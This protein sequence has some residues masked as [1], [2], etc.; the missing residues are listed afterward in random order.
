MSKAS[1][2]RAKASAKT[3]GRLVR[4]TVAVPAAVQSSVCGMFFVSG[5]ASLV[6]QVLWFKL[7]Q[8][9][10]GSSTYSVSVT[11]ASFFLGLALGSWLGGR[12]ADRW[13]HPLRNYG[14]LEI[15]LAGVSLLITVLLCRWQSWA[16]WLGPYLEIDSPLARPVTIGISFLLLL[17]PTMLMGATLPILVKYL[18]REQRALADQ[19]GLLYG[20]NTFGA[21]VG[22]AIAGFCLIA[23]FGIFQSA[24]VA[25][26]LYLVIG[27]AAL[28]LSGTF[29]KGDALFG[30]LTNADETD[31]A[32]VEAISRDAPAKGW[33]SVGT[34]VLVFAVS[35]F[36]SIAYEIIWFRLIANLGVHSVYAFSGMLTVYLL[37]LVL[38]SLVCAR[39]LARH[40]ER[41]LLY[42][43]RLQ[44]GIAV[45]AMLS[46]AIMGR[47]RMIV[48]I[49]T[50]MLAD[51]GIPQT[52]FDGLDNIQG[53]LL[54][55]LLVLLIPTVLI[56][57]GFPLASELTIRRLSVLGRRLG[58]LYALNTVGGV[59]GS[60]GAGFVLLPLLGS[61]WSLLLLCGMNLALFAAV[62]LSQPSLRRDR[63]LWREAAGAAVMIIV[64]LFLLGPDY[65]KN[66]LT[67]SIRGEVVAFEE[68]AE[69]TFVVIQYHNEP[70]GQYQQML[71]NGTSYAN[72][73]P[74][75]RRYMA[76]LAHLP[77]LLHPRPKDGVVICIGTGTTVGALTAHANIEKLYAVDLYPQVFDFAPHFVPLNHSFHRSQRVK[78]RVA[79]GRHFLLTTTEQFD[80]LTFEPPP[81]SNAGVV[82][83]YS[84]EFYWLAKLRLRLDGVVAQ[85]MPLDMS[86]EALPKMMIRS[87]MDEFPHVSLWIPNRMEGIAIASRQALKIDLEHLRRRMNAPGV[88]EDLHAIGFDTPESL[89]ATF[90]AG[91]EALARF[92]GDVPGVTDDRPRIEY[93]NFYPF[94]RM[95]Y[96]E[97]LAAREPVEK[98]LTEP[99]PDPK[100]LDQER[101]I[102]TAIWREHEAWAEKRWDDARQQI[103][104]GLALDPDNA[105]LLYLK[106]ASEETVQSE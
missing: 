66:S 31:T 14:F 60:L 51:C 75:G 58:V 91:D 106:A 72:N 22:C 104:K 103:E 77:A 25:S 1:F 86:R 23:V 69:G 45:A 41:L 49:F 6:C 105:Y 88:K 43:A 67:R 65:L 12:L 42:F 79:D 3:Q 90:V 59:L 70:A 27:I 54:Y 39:Y 30:A 48:V 24:L 55:C 98:Y 21:A 74:P 16:L 68:S 82:S 80:V 56:G 76:M 100:L 84:R 19:I 50:N 26:G 35:G 18:T 44:F 61:Q 92:V 101:Q 11:V 95:T 17:P 28:A 52:W 83:L 62:T 57:I 96:D 38:G 97:V 40:K 63:V 2:D 4:R 94:G 8:I 53:I 37:G 34:L 13:R 29:K 9:V 89:L 102:I 78:Q 93:F 20:I 7:L 71:Y 46:L 5:A 10:L 47:A 85:W 15:C 73:K 99:P 33:L 64:S 87:M 36:V 81:P 32:S